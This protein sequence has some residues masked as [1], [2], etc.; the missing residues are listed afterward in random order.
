MISL[1]NYF[2]LK[3]FESYKYLN[4]MA[5]NNCKATKGNGE[6]YKSYSMKD[7]DYCYVESEAGRGAT[8]VK[9]K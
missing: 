8:Y 6:Q 9:A 2:L 5:K 1:F 4:N 3:N 7:Y